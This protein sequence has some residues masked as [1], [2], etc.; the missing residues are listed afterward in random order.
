MFN[1]GSVPVITGPMILHFHQLAILIW[2]V[3]SRGSCMTLLPLTF[4]LRYAMLFIK[5]VLYSLGIVVVALKFWIQFIPA[6][7]CALRQKMR[8]SFKNASLL[9]S[10][11]VNHGFGSAIDGSMQDPRCQANVQ[12]YLTNGFVD[13]VDGT[14]CEVCIYF[15]SMISCGQQ[16]LHLNVLCFNLFVLTHP[17]SFH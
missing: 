14:V 11:S 17:E 9:T 6:L 4:G 3:L 12:R 16:S 2:T 5:L 7:N 1:N 8:E 10:R 15:H 13:F